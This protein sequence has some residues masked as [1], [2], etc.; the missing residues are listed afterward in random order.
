MPEPEIIEGQAGD[1]PGGSPSWL[2]YA[3]AMARP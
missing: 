3:T 2:P 1:S